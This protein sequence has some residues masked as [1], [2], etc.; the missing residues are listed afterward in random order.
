MHQSLCSYREALSRDG[1]TVIP[2]VYDTD[3]CEQIISLI[4]REEGQGPEFRRS[5]D[6]FAIRQ[7]LKVIP[8]IGPHLFTPALR[9][10][11]RELFGEDYFIVKAIYFDKPGQSNWLVAW[12]Q[13]LSISVDRQ[14]P[15]DGFGPWTAKQGQYAVQPPL[16][17]LQQNYTIRIHLDDTDEHNGALKVISGSHAWGISRPEALD[18]HATPATSCPVAAG[19]IMIMRPLLMHASSRST[20]GRNRRVV[21]IE[22]SNQQLPGGLSWS[23]HY[24]IPSI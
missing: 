9:S 22:F 20:N 21:H 5:A 18:L 10:V 14:L 13:D 1:F 24:P 3:A 17:L 15:V 6:L 11:I 23:E 4:S 2:G 8:G 19:S 12:H 7:L 16:A